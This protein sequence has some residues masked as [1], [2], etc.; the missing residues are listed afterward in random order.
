MLE[1]HEGWVSRLH[2]RS[3][4]LQLMK[5]NHP[6]F[7]LLPFPK[8][9]THRVLP[10]SQPAVLK[11]LSISSRRFPLVSVFKVSLVH[12]PW[13][14]QEHICPT[15]TAQCC[16]SVAKFCPTLWPHRLQQSSTHQTSYTAYLTTVI[17]MAQNSNLL[18]ICISIFLSFCV[19]V[20]TS[21][22]WDL[23]SDFD[24]SQ[25]NTLFM[26]ILKHSVLIFHLLSSW[27]YN[28]YL[29]PW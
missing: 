17:V 27:L 9:L 20:K 22:C 3:Y 4:S 13:H 14:K 26:N 12:I 5:I 8:N 28:I 19:F 16:C 25:K 18:F 10:V 7:H 24:G 21:E 11:V 23:A 15:H 6:T 2:V 29:W 1:Q